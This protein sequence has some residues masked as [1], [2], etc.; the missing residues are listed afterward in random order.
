[1][2]N[3]GLGEAQ[4]LL[5]IHESTY[6]HLIYQRRRALIQM[7]SR[8]CTGQ[9]VRDF[10]AVSAVSDNF[11]RSILMAVTTSQ[12]RGLKGPS[13]FTCNSASHGSIR[14]RKGRL[15]VS[16]LYLN[17]TRSSLVVKELCM[18]PSVACRL[19]DCFARKLARQLA[20]V[21]PIHSKS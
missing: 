13:H 12:V 15:I 19:R 14:R 7:L 1:M 11:K 6:R 5:L 2:L 10:S 17:L 9:L 4:M 16:F 3:N 21:S 18:L 20:V 8:C